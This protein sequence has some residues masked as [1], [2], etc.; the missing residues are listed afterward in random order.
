MELAASTL[1]APG[2]GLETVLHWLADAGVYA[3]EL[4][5]AE[6][7]PVEPGMP[8]SERHRIRSQVEAA[9]VKITGIA[10][11][12]K[13]AQPGQDSPIIDD[14][15]A[16]MALA[17]DLG[18]ATVRVFPGA[19]MADAASTARDDAIRRA[20]Y[21]LSQVAVQADLTGVLPVIETHDSHPLGRDVAAMA[22]LVDG[23]V[24]VTWDLMH[25]WRA[26][27]SLE[28]TWA[29]LQPWLTEGNGSVQIKDAAPDN[30]PTLIGG[31]SLPCEEFGRLLATQRYAGTV[32]LE[33]EAAWYASAPPLPAA[34]ASAQS[35][36]QGT[37]ASR[38]RS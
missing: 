2:V 11:Y 4:R 21:R 24:G 27:E 12:V 15:S 38:A 14:L 9:G 25:P 35:W 34:L 33:L 1:G 28:E 13:I 29:A 26:G 30:T 17:R 20:A 19:D 7:E 8:R 32:T 5:A 10:S 16:H 37:L 22:R 23:P 18:A 3:V 6:G 31:G 36:M